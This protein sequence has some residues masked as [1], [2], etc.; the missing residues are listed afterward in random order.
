[1][2]GLAVEAEDDALPEGWRWADAKALWTEYAVPAAF[3]SFSSEVSRRLGILSD[4]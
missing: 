2:T 1:M 3:R 4:P